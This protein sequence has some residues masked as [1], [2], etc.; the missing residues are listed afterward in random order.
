MRWV[1]YCYSEACNVRIQ[2][3]SLEASNMA[4][5]SRLPTQFGESDRESSA[6]R[7]NLK[8]VR[9]LTGTDLSSN[10]HKQPVRNFHR[11]YTNVSLFEKNNRNVF[12]N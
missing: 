11:K 7:A 8:T 12:I 2:L 1:I 6:T 4:K 3:S 10:T 5:K 9:S